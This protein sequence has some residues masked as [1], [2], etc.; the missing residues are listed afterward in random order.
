MSSNQQDAVEL[1]A[2]DEEAIH[3]LAVSIKDEVLLEP[4]DP[5]LNPTNKEPLDD[6][7]NDPLI[8]QNK[9]PQDND[10]RDTSK[11]LSLTDV[12]QDVNKL[13]SSVPQESDVHGSSN[14]N[15]NVMKVEDILECSEETNPLN[16]TK[17]NDAVSAS[18][19]PIILSDS[20]EATNPSVTDTDKVENETVSNE[21]SSNANV[22]EEEVLNETATVV[23]TTPVSRSKDRRRTST[24]MEP[25]A[26]R[27]KR[28]NAP[29]TSEKTTQPTS[30][31]LSMLPIDAGGGQ[32]VA[33][34]P[35]WMVPH[36]V[37]TVPATMMQP[38]IPPPPPANVG[39][40]PSA[41]AAYEAY[42]QQMSLATTK[43][44][45]AMQLEQEASFANDDE[46]E[47]SSPYS[48][49]RRT[50][51]SSSPFPSPSIKKTKRQ[52]ELEKLH[53]SDVVVPELNDVYSPHITM[54]CTI[55]SKGP[56]GMKLAKW[57]NPGEAST[58]KKKSPKKKKDVS[59][60]NICTVLEVTM[61]GLAYESGIRVGDTFCRD[62]WGIQTSSFDEVLSL[63]KKPNRPLR[64]FLRRT[65]LGRATP[66]PITSHDTPEMLAPPSPE[67]EDNSEVDMPIGV[68]T[69]LT[70]PANANAKKKKRYKKP[71]TPPPKKKVELRGWMAPLSYM[72]FK[73]VEHIQIFKRERHLILSAFR[74][75]YPQ[76]DNSIERMLIYQEYVRFMYLKINFTVICKVKTM[77]DRAKMRRLKNEKKRLLEEANLIKGNEID[78]GETQ[79][80]HENDRDGND[81]DPMETNDANANAA[82]ENKENLEG[83][84]SSL[85]S[86]EEPENA[87]MKNIKIENTGSD[88]EEIVAATDAEENATAEDPN[89]TTPASKM[90]SSAQTQTD[91]NTHEAFSTLVSAAGEKEETFDELR[92]SALQNSK[93]DLS[94]LTPSMRVYQMWSCHVSCTREYLAFCKRHHELAYN[95]DYFGDPK[96]NDYCSSDEYD[97]DDDDDDSVEVASRKKRMRSKSTNTPIKRREVSPEEYFIHFDPEMPIERGSDYEAMFAMYE[98]RFGHAPIDYVWPVPS[99]ETNQDALTLPREERV[100]QANEVHPSPNELTDDPANLDEQVFLCK[101]GQAFTGEWLDKFYVLRD[102]FNSFQFD[103]TEVDGDGELNAGAVGDIS[104]GENTDANDNPNK[105]LINERFAGAVNEDY[106]RNSKAERFAHAAL[107]ALKDTQPELLSWAGS[108][109]HLRYRIRKPRYRNKQRVSILKSPLQKLAMVVDYERSELTDPNYTTLPAKVAAL[110]SFGFSFAP[111]QTVAIVSWEDMYSRLVDFYNKNRH[112]NVSHHRGKVFCDNERDLKRLANWVNTQ[113]YVHKLFQRG[114]GTLTQERIDLL[115]K[116]EFKWSMSLEEMWLTHFEELKR[117]KEKHGNCLVPQRHPEDPALSFWVKKQREGYRFLKQGKNSPLT[118]ARI[119]R[120]EEIGFVWKTR[121]RRPPQN[122]K[123]D[124]PVSMMSLITTR[125]DALATTGIFVPQIPGMDEEQAITNNGISIIHNGILEN[126]NE[127]DEDG[128]VATNTLEGHN[129]GAI[130]NSN[131]YGVKEEQTEEAIPVDFYEYMD[132]QQ[133]QHLLHQQQQHDLQQPHGLQQQQQPHGLQQQNGF[134]PPHGLQHHFQQQHEGMNNNL[135]SY[136]QLSQQIKDRGGLH[137]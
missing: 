125:T 134:Q 55:E 106:D 133:Q 43:Y 109:R 81:D 113:R 20:L 28:K 135:H 88:N 108:Q 114:E 94:R 122:K 82:N 31:P 77:M 74:F 14:N 56:V 63:I 29:F 85:P 72:P 61:G 40:S 87:D 6:N 101:P 52:K 39:K 37:Q 27:K 7:K 111:E 11:T 59:D 97:T 23:V 66:M 115:N 91:T 12:K 26:S 127:G 17:M 4:D 78:N 118:P 38:Y 16:V 50:R 58:T 9:E 41:K 42:I 119:E 83:S 3:D 67:A 24:Q 15:L 116:L 89:E 5:L 53:C 80:V 128:V 2:C 60:P 13:V 51:S 103:D 86:G 32:I 96:G 10:D 123:Y 79:Q 100:R 8:Q 131:T 48:L 25:V 92:I 137:L 76:Y 45:N 121:T 84:S 34:S 22:D 126:E 21:G 65:L 90:S 105:H 70:A 46:E 69:V 124:D 73:R 107:Q 112:S 71:K 117:Y 35:P 102:H 110:K 129:E 132:E 57:T 64:L 33:S 49:R 30:H 18:T 62:A 54:V 68:N 95:N 1:L 75:Q 47:T 130:N 44:Q 36:A 99:D 120:L 136:Q 93:Q 98:K 19:D 104:G